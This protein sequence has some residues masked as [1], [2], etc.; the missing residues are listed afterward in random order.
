MKLVRGV[1]LTAEVVVAASQVGEDRVEVA[2]L[3]DTAMSSK[4]SSQT[5]RLHNVVSVHELKQ[6]FTHQYRMDVSWSAK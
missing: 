1:V 4:G 5:A 2:G 6:M 3:L